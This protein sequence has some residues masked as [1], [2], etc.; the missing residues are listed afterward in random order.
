M[1]ELTD[2]LKVSNVIK[3][4]HEHCKTLLNTNKKPVAA[5]R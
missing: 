1:D 2:D 5:Q 3:E 4:I